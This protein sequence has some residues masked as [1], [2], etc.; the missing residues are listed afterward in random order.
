MNSD[1]ADSLSLNVHVA[2]DISCCYGI[3]VLNGGVLILCRWWGAF[4]RQLAPKLKNVGQR[5]LLVVGDG[6]LLIPSGEEGKRLEK[7]LPR[8]RLKVRVPMPVL[9]ERPISPV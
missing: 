6:D 8:C 5:V 9:G 3:I 4:N 7:A 2:Y 1:L